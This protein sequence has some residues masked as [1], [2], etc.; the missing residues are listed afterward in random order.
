MPPIL[1]SNKK[2]P[3][4]V[5]HEFKIY[6]DIHRDRLI[7]L[8]NRYEA[9]LKRLDNL[10]NMN[11]ILMKRVKDTKIKCLQQ[12]LKP[13]LNNQISSHNNKNNLISTR[14]QQTYR[15]RGHENNFNCTTN[16]SSKINNKIVSKLKVTANH[17]DITDKLDAMNMRLIHLTRCVENEN[18]KREQILNSLNENVSDLLKFIFFII[19]KCVFQSYE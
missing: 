2:I 16:H 5:I 10:E 8:K 18:E 6:R 17:D 1:A 14:D 7:K 12:T 4:Y 15:S 11:R 19:I 13:N 3:A 9:Y